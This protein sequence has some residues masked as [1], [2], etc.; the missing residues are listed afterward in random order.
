MK[1][2]LY[3]GGKF[4]RNITAASVREAAKSAGMNNFKEFKQC[5]GCFQWHGD[6]AIELIKE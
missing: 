2:S 5:V 3:K 1:F 4:I 6:T